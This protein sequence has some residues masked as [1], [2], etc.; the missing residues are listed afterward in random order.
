MMSQ[1]QSLKKMT[2]W[3]LPVLILLFG[4]M[5]R[6]A[7]GAGTTTFRYDQ[8]RL[9]QISLEMANGEL[10]PLLGIQ[11]SAG[12]PNS[13]MTVYVLAP[14]FALSSNPVVIALFI[15]LLNIIGLAVLW[16]IAHQYFGIGVA[17]IAILVYAVS[18]YAI[19]Y[20]RRIW[21]QNYHTPFILLGIWCGLEGFVQKKTWAQIACLPLLII[22]FQIHFAAWTLL[23]IY[24]C[25]LWL[26]RKNIRWGAVITSV[27][28]AIGVTIP[29]VLGILGQPAGASDRASMIANIISGGID[30][31]LNYVLSLVSDLVSGVGRNGQLADTAFSLFVSDA[32]WGAF[33]VFALIGVILLLR[34]TWR[35]YALLVWLWAGMTIIAFAPIWTGSG[36]YHHY[37]IPSLPA[38][39]LLIG[40]GMMGMVQLMQRMN[41]QALTQ[42]TRGILYSVLTVIVI[43]QSATVLAGYSFRADSY[44]V[45]EQTGQTATPVSYLLEVREIL[46]DYD[47]VILLGAN[48]HESNYYI[49]EPMLF[50][51]TQ[52]VRDLLILDGVIDVLPAGRFAA[53][54]APLNP[55]NANYEPPTRYTH[56]DPIEIS[57]REGED[58]YIIY[59]FESAPQWEETPMNPVSAR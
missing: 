28:L 58:P 20:S 49:W 50:N 9:A 51:E 56:D 27:I 53:V 23:P 38:F 10:F 46:Q 32:V 47:D 59:T 43:A 42:L 31:R 37:F 7:D 4:F 18:P 52:C 39:A 17:T 29:F 40:C 3:L 44:T 36:V 54:V 34:K 30:Y 5:M 12:V 45:N 13:P 1:K 11:S 22:G 8:A 25:L 21:A 55:I 6:V 57:L 19:E 48:P 41:N 2:V 35:H 26:G 24:L 33:V 16:R 14:F 15:I